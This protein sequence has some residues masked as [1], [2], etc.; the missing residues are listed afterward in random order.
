MK[1]TRR[2]ILERRLRGLHRDDSGQVMFFMAFG[3]LVLAALAFL[4]FNGGDQVNSQVVAQN[5]ADAAAMGGG[6][7]MA[8]GYNLI[9]M[10]NV[11]TTRLI[12]M[13]AVLE[14]VGPSL[15][16]AYPNAVAIEQHLAA[17][18]PDAWD[19][20]R[21]AGSPLTKEMWDQYLAARA[22]SRNCRTILEQ[23]RSN[24]AAMDAKY[25][26]FPQY[27]TAFDG[28]VFWQAAHGLQE[29]SEYMVTLLPSLAQDHAVRMGRANGADTAFLTPICPGLF[30][31][32]GTWDDYRSPILEGLPPDCTDENKAYTVGGYHTLLGYPRGRGYINANPLSDAGVRKRLR[33]PYRQ[34]RADLFE[35]VMD[36]LRLSGFPYIFARIA[37]VKMNAILNIAPEPV[38][39]PRWELSYTEASR[40]HSNGAN[41]VVRVTPNT[42][43]A[44]PCALRDAAFGAD[45]DDRDPS[46]Y[47]ALDP[48]DPITSDRNVD[49]ARDVWRDLSGTESA[50]RVW[51][52]DRRVKTYDPDDMGADRSCP[53]DGSD[54]P[55]EPGAE[56]RPFW[57][58]HRYEKWSFGGALMDTDTYDTVDNDRLMGDKSG[59]YP[60]LLDT[61]QAGIRQRYDLGVWEYIAFGIDGGHAKLWSRV[62]GNPNPAEK[63]IAYA[64]VRVHN[65]T[66]WDLFTQDWRAT[67]VPA[68]HLMRVNTDAFPGDIARY[69]Q[70]RDNL[71][72]DDVRPVATLYNRLPDNPSVIDEINNH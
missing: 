44:R 41:A 6:I 4:V 15:E 9:A 36:E 17:Y 60:I 34:Y 40:K 59:Y 29:F 61:S 69:R 1:K 33:G 21:H 7:W 70:W 22:E 72:E 66:S 43:R 62:F 5:A 24:L 48:V 46:R 68:A 49:S 26:G 14:A 67:L 50:D 10:N 51:W 12:A 47:H 45:G 19:P 57:Y 8:R 3:M 18:P 53:T 23:L 16:L 28:G 56:P 65:P 27:F 31:R 32:R 58:Y 42:R 30:V 63:N 54:P 2:S 13:A 38:A 39:V 11:A 37:S 71:S 20:Y 64:Q 35:G 25:G 55:D 52:Y